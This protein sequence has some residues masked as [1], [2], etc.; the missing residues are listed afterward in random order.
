[1]P[2]GSVTIAAG[3]TTAQFTVD[4]PQGALGA[5]PDAD[6]RSAGQL[7]RR[8]HS[9]L[10]ADRARRRSSTIKPEAGNPAVPELAYLGNDGSFT[11]DATTNTYTLNLGGV[12]QG[13]SIDAAEFAVVNAADDVSDNLDGDFT[14]PTGEGFIVTGDNLPSPLAAGEDYEGLYISVNTAD[15]GAN[16]MS[17]TFDPE[18][19]NDSGYSQALTPLTLKIVDFGRRR[20]EAAGSTRRRPSSS[21]PCMSARRSAST[22]ASPTR[23]RPAPPISMSR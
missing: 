10:R 21:P 20:G 4:V 2:T 22:S 17:L 15:L 3:Q 19:V 18:D 6:A 12:T 16:G 5:L 1:M 8:R 9:D 14:A 11:F 7:A 23:P 13:A